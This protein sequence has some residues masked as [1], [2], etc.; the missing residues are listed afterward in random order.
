MD[1]PVRGARKCSKCHV[2][3]TV[4]EFSYRRTSP[5]GLHQWCKACNSAYQAAYRAANRDRLTQQKR[6][7][8]TNVWSKDPDR[9]K[10]HNEYS[11]RWSKDNADRCRRVKRERLSHPEEYRKYLES[12]KAYRAKPETKNLERERCLRHK[13]GLSLADWDAIF[14]SQ[15]CV[16]AICKR[17]D[18]GCRRTWH[19]DH[20]HVAGHVRGILCGD[21]NL[22]LGHA[23]ESIET[24]R[25]MIRYLERHSTTK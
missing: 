24:L 3:K 16:C 22:A 14:D 4:D 13:F 12:G 9:R 7:Y 5:D 1:L 17:A 21:C 11:L 6:D 23:R 25:S 8:Y 20:C 10:R 19:T 2:E 15:G 18:P